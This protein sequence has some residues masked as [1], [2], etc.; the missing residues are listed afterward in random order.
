M[1][2][3]SKAKM[4]EAKK[5]H[6]EN[7]EFREK[8]INA[9]SSI[10]DETRQKMSD[11]K[12]RNWQDSDY[13]KMMSDAHLGI[14]PVNK[15]KPSEFRGEKHPMFGKH[16]TPESLAIMSEK[17]KA[18]WERN[19]MT[20]E[21][22]EEMSERMSGE[23]NH[24]FGRSMPEETKKKISEAKMGVKRGPHSLEHRRK[25]S[26]A[27]SGPTNHRYIDGKSKERAAQRIKEMDGV[28]Y[29]EWRKQVFERDGYKCQHCPQVGGKLHADHIK[30]WS[31]HPELRYDVKNGR[32]LCVSCHRKTPTWGS[33]PKKT[34]VLKE[35][36]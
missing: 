22:R 8:M 15:G 4:R 30:P 19:P 31:T 32:T 3:E 29:R 7:P 16:H 11:A 6:W 14:S 1:S 21:R 13:H 24:N 10:S 12:S 33:R 34:S 23:K 17:S 36:K 9:R 26:K 25:I 5:R 28:A 2:D 18:A 20:D 27:N 35:N